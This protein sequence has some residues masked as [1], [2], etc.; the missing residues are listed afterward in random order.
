VRLFKPGAACRDCGLF[1]TFEDKQILNAFLD[2]H[3][4]SP[5]AGGRLPALACPVCGSGNTVFGNMKA[6]RQDDV[7][8]FA[9]FTPHRKPGLLGFLT[10]VPTIMTGSGE[11]AFACRDCGAIV[12]LGEK[13]NLKRLPES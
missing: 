1:W 12:D 10:Y 8:L 3:C 13:E 5:T 2:K 6:A 4:L 7:D 11:Q 9:G